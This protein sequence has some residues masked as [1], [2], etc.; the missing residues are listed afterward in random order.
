MSK[1]T[2]IEGGIKEGDMVEASLSA[3]GQATS[4]RPS[5]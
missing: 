1:A 5:K 4:I 2:K 3:E